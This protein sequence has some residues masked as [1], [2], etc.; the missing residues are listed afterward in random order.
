M[1][2]PFTIFL[3]S[4]SY[5]RIYQAVNML[6]TASSMG[7]RCHLFL[8]Y[9]ALEAFVGGEWDNTKVGSIADES[10]A[11]LPG[12]EKVA[13]AFELSNTP[14]LYKILEAARDESGGV[15]VCAC[16]AS[17]QM[18]GLDPVEVKQKVDEIVGLAT[19]LE[20]SSHDG[21]VLYL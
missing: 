14:S 18:L 10:G 2:G 16:S 4:S 20:L 8:F 21:H 1:S 7:R 3:H 12:D 19:M 9:Q 6:L 17:V 11:A 13:E 5:D 15:S